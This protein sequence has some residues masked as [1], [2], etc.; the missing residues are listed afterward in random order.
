M[1]IASI[2]VSMELL[3]ANSLK[4]RRAVLNSIKGKLKKFNVSVIDV[5]GEYPKEAE[6]AI[7]FVSHNNTLAMQT[8]QSI[9]EFMYKNFPEVGFDISY[10]FL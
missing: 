3:F 9:E 4:E 2:S 10:E 5:S 6:L 8:L 7:V 1:V